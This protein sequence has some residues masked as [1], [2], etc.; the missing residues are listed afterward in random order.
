MSGKISFIAQKGRAAIYPPSRTQKI[1]TLIIRFIDNLTYLLV[2][3]PVLQKKFK[4]LIKAEP[5]HSDP[6]NSHCS[7]LRD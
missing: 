4:N 7:S 2:Y 1:H 6:K 5:Q 3:I